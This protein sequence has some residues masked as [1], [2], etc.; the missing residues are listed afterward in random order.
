[1]DARRFSYSTPLIDEA[2]SSSWR[3]VARLNVTGPS[4][5]VSRSIDMTHG[6]FFRISVK[7]GRRSGGNSMA[8]SP[9]SRSWLAVIFPIMTISFFASGPL[10]VVIAIK[11]HF[12][13]CLVAMTIY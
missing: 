8:S 13:S 6:Y 11:H 12:C 1:V 3:T 4:F 5:V 10:S 9:V 2:L 7:V